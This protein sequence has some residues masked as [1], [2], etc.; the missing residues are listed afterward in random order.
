MQISVWKIF[1]KLEHVIK[2]TQIVLILKLIFLS[3]HESAN[4]EQISL[5]S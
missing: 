4:K 1:Q 5:V 3:V 2:T